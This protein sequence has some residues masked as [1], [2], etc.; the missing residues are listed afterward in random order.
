MKIDLKRIALVTSGIG[1]SCLFAAHSALAQTTIP[2]S[3]IGWQT[4]SNCGA[5]NNTGVCDATPE[6][7]STF[8]ATPVGS[9]GPD[10]TYLSGV[11][12]T[13]ASAAGRRG[14]G[15]QTNNGFLNGDGFGNEAADATREIVNIPL[16]DGSPGVRIGPFGSAIQGAPDGTSSWKFST[17]ANERTGDISITNESSF[18]FRLQFIHLD[19]RVGNGNSPQNLEIKYLS[20]DGTLYDN[21]LVRLDNGNELVDLNNIYN[22]DFGPGPVTVNV[23][24]SIGGTIGT[25]AYLAPGASAGFRFVWTDFLT[26]GAESQLDNVAFEGQF[27]LTDQLQ[28]QIDVPEPA[29]GGALPCALV[30]FSAMARRRSPTFTPKARIL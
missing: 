28:T 6:S 10:N 22:T 1:L 19:G 25:Q 20:G 4:Y 21:A 15:Q 11:I 3:F 9:I 8:D 30:L 2:S 29:A 18:Y 12:G 16:A 27:F 23:S 26:N 17:S 24:H 13:D 7:N 5:T 14:R